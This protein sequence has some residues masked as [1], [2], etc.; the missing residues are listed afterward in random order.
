MKHKINGKDLYYVGEP[1]FVGAFPVRSEIHVAPTNNKTSGWIVKNFYSSAEVYK[2]NDS[3]EPIRVNL[4]NKED[5]QVGTRV[6]VPTLFGYVNMV[7]AKDEDG[8]LFADSENTS[9]DLIFD[10]DDRHCWTSSCAFNKRAMSK[11]KPDK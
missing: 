6:T 3:G 2:L 5:L 8:E 11:I 1:E 9:A 10:E 7:I 4:T